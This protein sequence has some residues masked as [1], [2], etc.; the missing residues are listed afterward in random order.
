[1]TARRI[2]LFVLVTLIAA[3]A[4]AYQFDLTRSKHRGDTVRVSGNIELIDVEV[5]FKIP[6]RVEERLV[7][8]GE[9]VKPGQLLAK[10]DPRDLKAEADLRQAEVKAAEAALAELKNGSRP[11]EI[12]AALAAKERAQA[13][14]DELLHGSRPQ[15]IAVAQAAV[16]SAR[17]E[18][19]RLNAERARAEGLFQSRT[20]SREEYDRQIAAHDV[21]VARLAEAN[22]RLALVQE[23]PRREQI[24]AAKAALAQA[25]SQYDLVKRGPRQELIDQAAAKLAQA[26]AGLDLAEIRLSYATLTWHL[27]WT[28]VVMSKNIEPREYVSAGTPIITVG[29]ITHVWLRAYI[30]DEE[31]RSV[32]YGQKV[33]VTTD[34]NSGKVYEGVVAFIASEAEF[35]PKSVQTPKERTKLVYRIKVNIDNPNMELKRGMPADGEILVGTEPV[36]APDPSKS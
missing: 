12:A 16:T 17:V 35:T 32:K 22:E 36:V 18:V 2:A 27:P 15:E 6:G 31:Q 14:L 25:Q 23:G 13:A 21:A 7:D 19:V 30:S 29:D 33:R 11:E 34:G 26:K 4:V 5:S 1:M 8:E 20:I 24:D 9:L 10:L 3:A 28:G